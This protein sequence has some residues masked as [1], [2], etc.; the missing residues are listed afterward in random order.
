MDPIHAGPLL[1]IYWCVDYFNKIRI[2]TEINMTLLLSEKIKRKL[3]CTYQ[4]I[5]L[6]ENPK[7][8]EPMHKDVSIMHFNSVKQAAT[9]IEVYTVHCHLLHLLI[10]PLTV[11]K[12]TCIILCECCCSFVYYNMFCLMINFQQQ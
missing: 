5:F 12:S 11:V 9:I 2:L 10:Q 4:Q 1:F 3:I 6:K 8:F 7:Q